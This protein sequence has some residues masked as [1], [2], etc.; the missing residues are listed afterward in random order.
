MGKKLGVVRFLLGIGMILFS[1]WFLLF[2]FAP[3][4]LLT[5]M[6]AFEPPGLYLRLYGIFPLSWAILF[7]FALKDVGKNV[8]IIKAAII[9][10]FLTAISLLVVRFVFKVTGWF[11]LVS[12]IILVVFSLLL[13]IYLPKKAVL[14]A[15]P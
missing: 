3:E 4:K 14:Q 2:C 9:T 10:G 5:A 12:L 1:L 13:W 15:T 11:N 6:Q 7:L 8:A